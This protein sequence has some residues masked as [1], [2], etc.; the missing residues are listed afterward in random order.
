MIFTIINKFSK[1]IRV[2]LKNGILKRTLNRKL[3]EETSRK[4]VLLSAEK[5]QN[6]LTNG[7]LG[8]DSARIENIISYKKVALENFK[9]ISSPSEFQKGVVYPLTVKFLTFLTGFLVGVIAGHVGFLS[10][11]F[12]WFRL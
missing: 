9:F 3:A 6:E 5:T 2:F 10:K 7:V 1:P 11:I 8:R 12:S 4:I